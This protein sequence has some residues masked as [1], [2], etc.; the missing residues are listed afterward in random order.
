MSLR[1]QLETWRSAFEEHAD[2]GLVA[3]VGALIRQLGEAGLAAG[4]VKAGDKAPPFRCGCDDG[5]VTLSG[6]LACGP[7]VLSFFR[8]EWCP[9]CVLELAALSEAAGEVERLG[10]TIVALSPHTAQRS[11][12]P[13]GR[14][15]PS[16]VVSQDR[17]GRIARQYRIA[18]TVP[19]PYR[20]A[21]L[22]LGLPGDA[23][24]GARLWRL[25][26]PA[27]Y[28]IDTS[29]LI[30]LSYL[31]PDHTTRLDPAEI[32]AALRRLRRG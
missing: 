22:A 25:P 12:S 8:G 10:A 5:S 3:A 2:P 14:R 17:G 1:A 32:V 28:V 4:A 15:P 23:S 30:V 7:V 29:G 6:L 16:F 24:N 9:Y 19:R 27:T 18:F 31:D 26:I 21:Y 20:D 13:T 11:L